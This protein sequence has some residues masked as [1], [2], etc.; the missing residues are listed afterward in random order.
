MAGWLELPLDDA[1]AVIVCGLNEGFVP[2]SVNSDLFLP[3]LLRHQ[4]GLQDNLR[5][6][7]RDAYALTVLLATR[8]RVELIVPRRSLDGDP[9][10]PSRLLFATDSETLARRAQRFFAP[11]APIHGLPPLAGSLVAARDLPD[12]PVPRPR[13]L[14]ESIQRIRVTAF[15][16]YLACPYRF[17]LR[18]VLGLQTVDDGAEELDGAAFGNLLHDVM[19]EFG[20]GAF[21]DSTDPDEIRAAFRQSLQR[22]VSEVFDGRPL[23]TVG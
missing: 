22:H 7:A 2:S 23:A 18:H 14:T 9:L 15:R 20:T 5:R 13:R 17:Y 8:Q 10:I 6:Y 4:L 19:R 1:P 3:D 21:R 12:F 11:P 16:D